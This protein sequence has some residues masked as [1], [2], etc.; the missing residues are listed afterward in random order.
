VRGLVR[1]TALLMAIG[2]ISSPVQSA[3]A[4]A[5]SVITLLEAVA[6]DQDPR[7]AAALARIDGTG[8]Q[9]LALRGYLRAGTGL[10][11]RWS[12]N[13]EQIAAFA[14]S[15]ENRAMQAEIAGVRQAFAAANPGYELWVN[16]QVRSLDIQLRNWNANASV[17][18]AGAGMLAA[19]EKWRSSAAEAM[20]VEEVPRAAARFI[21]A[22]APSPIPTLAAPGL[23]PHGQMRAVDFQ[24][25]KDGKVIAG[26][27]SATIAS[28]W[29]ATGWAA[30]LQA[31]VLAGSDRFTGP[32]ASP[33]EPWHYTYSAELH[34]P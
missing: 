31:A 4:P 7:V 3:G 15:P 32:L 2:T 11:G 10:A 25:R 18:R 21:A 13:S 34:E 26:P 33:R 28:A 29:D 1:V 14:Q 27:V 22:F 16:P 30:K 24:I 19:V 20:S 23:S 6:A 9:L 12:W 17:S 8:R 5:D